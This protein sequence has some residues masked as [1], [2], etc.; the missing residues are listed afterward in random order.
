LDFHQASFDQ[1][2]F[3]RVQFQRKP[4][5]SQYCWSTGG[6]MQS[7]G[8]WVEAKLIV[9][10]D[11]ARPHITSVAERFLDQNAMKGVFH[12]P[13][14]PDFA[15]SDFSLFSHVKQ[16]LAGR[17][18][19]DGEARVEVVNVILTDIE[20]VTSGKVFLEWGERLRKCIETNGEYVD[21][22]ISRH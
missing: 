14:S 4:L 10:A 12:P 8:G 13:D 16:L 21:S 6:L 9:C 22:T 17:E 7:S 18:F 19:P 20:K 1:Y 15:S 5:R 2:F 11:N 3:Q